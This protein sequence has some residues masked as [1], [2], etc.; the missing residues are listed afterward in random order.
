MQL[1]VG[2]GNPGRPYAGT[3]HNIGWRVAEAVADRAGL[4][5]WREKFDALLAEGPRRGRKVAVA[6]PTTFM[7]ESGRSVRQMVD[8]W[9]LDPADLL[10][11]VDDMALDLGRLRLRAAGSAGGHNGLASI[12]AHVGHEAF[13]RLRV[14][15]G[16]A[17]ERDDH[18]DFVLGPFSKE[19]QPAVAEAVAQAVDAALVWLDRGVEAAMNQFNR[20]VESAHDE[21]QKEEASRPTNH[22]NP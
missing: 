10:V 20:P 7:N 12:V 1:I 9:R 19:E 8:F 4:G 21:Q 18:V 3:R 15:I 16:P 13:A 17:P 5:P 2:L 22:A 11:I 14:G 6:R